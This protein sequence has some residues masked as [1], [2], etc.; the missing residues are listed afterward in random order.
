MTAGE[1]VPS[2]TFVSRSVAIWSRIAQGIP[3]SAALSMVGPA[4]LIVLGYGF[5]IKYGASCLDRNL[6]GLQVANITLTPQPEWVTQD[7]TE[8][9]YKGGS[10]QRLSLLERDA[11]STV[12]AAFAN[13]PWIARVLRVQKMAGAQIKVDVEYRR[14]F[15]WIHHEKRTYPV[16]SDGPAAVVDEYYLVDAQGVNLPRDGFKWDDITRFFQVYCPNAP[17]P[18]GTIGSSY[19]DPRILKALKVAAALEPVRVPLK[20][21][22]INVRPEQSGTFVGTVFDVQLADGRSAYWGHAPGE[23]T[24]DEATAATKVEKLRAQI[25]S[26]SPDLDTVQDA[27]TL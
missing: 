24:P 20:L 3:R 18:R 8:E 17:Q 21:E 2:R 9:V 5:W 19:G 6:Y 13:H 25:L 16:S 22:R 10:L 27:P 1:P 15:A 4:L 12:A 14:P 7:I 23:E 11:T 26:G